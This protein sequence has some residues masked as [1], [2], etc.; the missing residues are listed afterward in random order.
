MTTSVAGRCP[1]CGVQ[2]LVLEDGG[3]V[4]CGSPAGCPDSMAATKI[5]ADA[6]TAHV[7]SV[8]EDGGW[9]ARHPLIERVDD[10]LLSCALGPYLK[11]EASGVRP[12]KYRVR[13]CS[14]PDKPWTWER[15]P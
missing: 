8:G 5:L 11:D 1:A 15:L 13:R 6:E 12:G 10:A 9:T 4:V 3:L 2:S 14:D 7:V